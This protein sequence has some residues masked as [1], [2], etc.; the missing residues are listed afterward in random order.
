MFC[1]SCGVIVSTCTLLQSNA[2][3]STPNCTPGHPEPDERRRGGA[4]VLKDRF[5]FSYKTGSCSSTQS[6]R[7]KKEVANSIKVCLFVMAANRT[8]R[9]SWTYISQLSLHGYIFSLGWPKPGDFTQG[10]TLLRGF[11]QCTCKDKQPTVPISTHYSTS[12]GGPASTLFITLS[13]A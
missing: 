12:L 6:K 4:N 11:N 10:R 3:S 9:S 8:Y 13:C 1:I 7:K 5:N 2:C